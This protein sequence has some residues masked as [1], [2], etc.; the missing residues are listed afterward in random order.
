MNKKL[1]L[2][3]I[4]GT[5]ILTGGVA[6]GV[7]VESV[8]RVL[9][10][11]IQWTISD[12]VGN[13]DQ[14]ILFTLFRRNGGIEPMLD[15]MVEQALSLYLK[16]LRKELAKDGI[17]QVLPG[18]KKLLKKME[19]T[20]EFA[21]GLVSGNVREGARIKLSSEKLFKY[22]PI[23]AF[24]DDALKRENLPPFAISRA[25]KYYGCFFDRSNIWIVG[26]SVNDI[27]CAHAN[28]LRCLAVASGHEKEAE[29]QKHH[30]TK[31]LSNLLD[32]EQ[33][34]KCLAS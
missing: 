4:D 1:I 31:L 27:K 24:G 10:R 29:L 13:T 23:G 8:S 33:V 9:Q 22:F 30:P 5:L 15:D 11:P 3:D 6:V 12:F 32:T 14:S 16:Q 17:V 28:R 18:V 34:I 2:F 26:D 7:M 19:K 25:E 20:P 21:L